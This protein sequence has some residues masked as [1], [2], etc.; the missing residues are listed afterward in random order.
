MEEQSPPRGYEL[1]EYE[2]HL[3]SEAREAALAE[4]ESLESLFDAVGG[5]G[6]IRIPTNMFSYMFGRIGAR[7]YS[8][9]PKSDYPFEP[10][11]R[12][13]R[14]AQHLIE[15]VGKKSPWI[16]PP[17]GSYLHCFSPQANLFSSAHEAALSGAR[18][19]WKVCRRSDHFSPPIRW[20]RDENRT[21]PLFHKAKKPFFVEPKVPFQTAEELRQFLNYSS[22]YD[23]ERLLLILA[24]TD[25]SYFRELAERI[26]RESAEAEER[27]LTRLYRATVEASSAFQLEDARVRATA[28]TYRI[29]KDT[30]PLPTTREEIYRE[31]DSLTTLFDLIQAYVYRNGPLPPLHVRAGFITLCKRVM[32]LEVE[33]F[34]DIVGPCRYRLSLLEFHETIEAAKDH[35]RSEF[36]QV[37]VTARQA[38]YQRWREGRG[39]LVQSPPDFS[40]SKRK[41]EP[42]E[43]DL[44]AVRDAISRIGR[45]DA[46]QEAVLA[47]VRK[48]RPM[49]KAKLGNALRTLADS[50][51]YEG[52]FRP[53]RR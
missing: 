46:K 9:N 28:V 23:E 39:D 38:W 8:V 17:P 31:C 21:R 35:W 20:M 26:R 33:D 27:V 6:P 52:R 16:N 4:C 22:W 15:P 24:G 30:D 18:E 45:R 11:L 48:R 1:V 14:K 40:F 3:V 44:Q 50:G 43:A 13:F 42:T 32:N 41:T 49:H 2:R 53:K 29:P 7:I 34:E 19:F 37:E 10:V 25:G 12:P 5:K 51:E 47:E 36:A